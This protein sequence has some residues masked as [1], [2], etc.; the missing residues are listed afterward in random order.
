MARGI[1]F[2]D[3]VSTVSPSYAREIMTG[4]YGE[5]LDSLLRSR[6]DRVAG[7]LNGIDAAAYDPATDKHIAAP[8][9]ADDPS[10]KK[11]A[12]SP[13]S[14]NSACRKSSGRPLL[15]I[16]SRLVEQKGLELLDQVV[17][18][19]VGQT[20]AQLVL[21]GSGQ[22]R[23]RGR[24]PA[25]CA[26]LPRSRR[27]ATGLRRGARAARVRR[28]RCVPHAVALRAVRPWADDRAPL[29][30]RAHC[31]RH[32]RIERHRARRLEG[33]GF[34]FH[35]YEARHFAEAIGRAMHAYRDQ[36]SWAILR[37]RGM[38]EDNS[39]THAAA[40][41]VTLYNHALRANGRPG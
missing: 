29:R 33:N 15:G 26:K 30:Q 21:L 2:S 12:N 20:D 9:D 22:P 1:A 16:V 19:I 14:V 35:P 36:K 39:W 5:R 6:R 32:R 11:R 23:V 13:S 3:M 17:P 18:W 27:R 31:S 37:E 7:I 34:R 10:G 8:F 40:Q 24:I 4:E 41:Y 25:A 38:R 28:Q